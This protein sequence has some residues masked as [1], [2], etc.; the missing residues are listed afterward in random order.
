MYAI[1]S[2]YVDE[3]YKLQPELLHGVAGAYVAKHLFNVSD[4]E[5][6][7]AIVY[8]TVPRLNMTKLDKII[9]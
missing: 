3:T 1:R 6:L 7:D 5:I 9:V 2:Y 8:H 4:Q